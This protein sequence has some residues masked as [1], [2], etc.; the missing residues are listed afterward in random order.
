MSDPT[1]DQPVGTEPS[2][3]QSMPVEA[4]QPEEQDPPVTV[5]GASSSLEGAVGTGNRA[6][7]GTDPDDTVNPDGDT[8][9]GQNP[10]QDRSQRPEE[11]GAFPPSEKNQAA[12][13]SGGLHTEGL[14]GRVE[15]ALEDETPS[16]NPAMAEPQY[17]GPIES[18]ADVTVPEEL[19]KPA[20]QVVS[21]ALDKSSDD[22]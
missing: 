14:A 3:A 16:Q 19:S 15:A 1:P 17:T 12:F 22:G 5:A 13:K 4:Q 10:P 8:R 7:F 21:D 20:G 2:E 18:M 11:G 9:S 6:H